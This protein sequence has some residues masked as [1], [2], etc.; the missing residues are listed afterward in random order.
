M[1]FSGINIWELIVAALSNF[2]LGFLWYG[3]P[4]FGTAWQKLAGLSD[5]DIQGGNMALIFGL[6]FILNFI[7][8][9]FISVFAEIA[10]M[11]GTSAIL[12]GIFA[13]IICLGFVATT[14]GINYLYHRKP[15]K[16]Y[17]INVGYFMVSFFIMGLIIGAW[18]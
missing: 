18:H 3:K 16:L 12:A 7:I 1:D 4:L 11:L 8:A 14:F 10:M 15:M 9:A 2:V 13:A 17:L 5:E 6:S